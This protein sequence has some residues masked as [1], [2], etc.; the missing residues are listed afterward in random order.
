ML[1]IL[2]QTTGDTATTSSGGNLV[3]TLVLYA[4]VIGGFFYLFMI[5]PQRTRM[6]R[7]EELLAQLGV[8]DEVQTIGGIY[9]RIEFLDD[10]TAILQVEGGGRLRVA[11]RALAGKTSAE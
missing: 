3:L 1:N 11:R 6:R 2:A 7:Q 8:G 4:V 10:T 9:G 5:R